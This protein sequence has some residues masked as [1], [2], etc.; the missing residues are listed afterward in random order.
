MCH[1][2]PLFRYPQ[3]VKSSSGNSIHRLPY[4]RQADIEVPLL[5]VIN[6]SGGEL[7][8]K[9]AVRLV[10]SLFPRLT[11]DELSKKLPSG[12]GN[13]WVNRVQ[14]ARQHLVSIGELDRSTRGIWRITEKGRNR[15][16]GETPS[17]KRPSQSTLQDIP[18]AS[19]RPLTITQNLVADESSLYEPAL[20]WLK[21][22]WG[23]EITDDGDEYWARVTATQ[24]R[25]G[26]LGKWSRPDLTSIQVYRFD[27]LPER[28][29]EVSTFEV[30]RF[31]DSTD[32]ASVYEAASH[33]RWAQ[34]TYLVVEVPDQDTRLQEYLTTEAARFGVGLLV[35]YRDSTS[36]QYE[37]EEV[38]GPKRQSPE[39]KEL[40]RMLVDFFSYSERELRKFRDLIR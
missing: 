25:R 40:D 38:L 20:T 30:K 16:L 11:E 23:K 12:V 17:Q 9:D 27:V 28:S 6:D 37:M 4:P 26:Q 15:L 31:S 19:V 5:K 21:G 14:W 18:A 36:S 7:R 13:Y 10:T 2:V 39:P 8:M 22:N 29:I 24:A 1:R 34:Y 35:M 32:L 33:Q 3:T